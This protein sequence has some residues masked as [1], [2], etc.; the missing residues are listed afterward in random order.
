M[1]MRM[2]MRMFMINNFIFLDYLI[3]VY[4]F[5]TDPIWSFVGWHFFL[6]LKGIDNNPLIAYIQLYRI[7]AFIHS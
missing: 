4:R 6:H 7:S 2:F 3:D 5:Y 1:F